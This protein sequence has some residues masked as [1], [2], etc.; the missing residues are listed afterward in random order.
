[1]VTKQ[2]TLNAAEEKY[3]YRNGMAHHA[4]YDSTVNPSGVYFS[5]VRQQK[6]RMHHSEEKSKVGALLLSLDRKQF[7]D[8]MQPNSWRYERWGCCASKG[9]RT[10]KY[11]GIGLPE[12]LQGAHDNKDLL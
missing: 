3:I 6:N 9:I 11:A 12:I 7:T 1:M 4:P 2:G 8:L 10:P 5:L